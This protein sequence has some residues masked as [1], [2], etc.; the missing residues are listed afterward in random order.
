M[1]TDQIHTISDT[2][3]SH[4]L[5]DTRYQKTNTDHSYPT[6]T[7]YDMGIHLKK[8]LLWFDAPH[9]HHDV[10]FL[11]QTPR[12]SLPK[13]GGRFVTNPGVAALLSAQR[14]RKTNEHSSVPIVCEFQK[15]LSIG[16]YQMEFLSAGSELG[17]SSI[18]VHTKKHASCLYAPHPMP[19][20]SSLIQKQTLKESLVLILTSNCP[21]LQSPL[22][23]KSAELCK[24]CTYLTQY[25]SENKRYP[26]LVVS[27]YLGAAQDLVYELSKH[28]I[29]IAVYPTIYRTNQIYENHNITLG[30]YSF[31]RTIKHRDKLVIM[32][33]RNIQ[34][35]REIAY[36]GTPLIYISDTLSNYRQYKQYSFF[37]KH[38]LI[39]QQSTWK[40]LRKTIAQVKPQ[41][42][43]VVGNHNKHYLHILKSMCDLP[44][45]LDINVLY[46][47]N[48]PTLFD[49]VDP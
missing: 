34:K 48:Q 45:K 44:P 25:Y 43:I 10:C 41:R 42:L 1:T 21:D 29:D 7:A 38:I 35:L 17:G 39:N 15:P 31:C 33:L 14:Y 20:S 19:V 22:L 28:N 40:D 16:S 23:N 18:F 26:V 12:C 13:F 36:Q 5:D 24:L 37:Q 8:S 4:T 27:S 9:I 30:A 49:L 32:P 11:S 46:Q 6:F 2:P 47:N 3:S